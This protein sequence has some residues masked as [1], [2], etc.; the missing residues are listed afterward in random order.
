VYR[1]FQFH[2]RSQ[3][4]I[5]AHDETLLRSHARPR[6]RSFAPQNQRLDTHRKRHAESQPHSFAAFISQLE[7]QAQFVPQFPV[8]ELETYHGHQNVLAGISRALL[9]RGADCLCLVDRRNRPV[10]GECPCQRCIVECH[11]IREKRLG[12]SWNCGR[13]VRSGN[14]FCVNMA[15]TPTGAFRFYDDLPLNRQESLESIEGTEAIAKWRIQL[16]GA[17]SPS[18]KFGR[19]HYRALGVVWKT[20]RRS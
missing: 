3:Y 17:C 20:C 15:C 19:V 13:R 11:L 5:G 9:G 1:P 8:A 4:F 7:N 18:L 16:R 14:F 12:S 10:E 2:E 6:S